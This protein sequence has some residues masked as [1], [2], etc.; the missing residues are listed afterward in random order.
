MK[1]LGWM[2]GQRE[3]VDDGDRDVKNELGKVLLVAQPHRCAR[4]ERGFTMK[5]AHAGGDLLARK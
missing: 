3:G 4:R 1:G 5:I 2:F